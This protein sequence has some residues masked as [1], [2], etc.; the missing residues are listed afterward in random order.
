M[1]PS[2]PLGTTFQVVGTA[3]TQ[4]SRTAA[5]AVAGAT[6]ATASA[7]TAAARRAPAR[8]GARWD[9]RAVRVSADLDAELHPGVD[10]AHRVERAP[11][12]GADGLGDLLLGGDELRV[13]GLIEAHGADVHERDGRRPLGL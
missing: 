2:R 10:D 7:R 8:P 3:P 1:I 4:T 6:S 5:C 9:R 13:A 11:L 12:L